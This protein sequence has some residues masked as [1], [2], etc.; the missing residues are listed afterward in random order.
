[1][2][3]NTDDLEDRV[4]EA[5]GAPHDS[6]R[7]VKGRRGALEARVTRMHPAAAVASVAVSGYV[8]ICLVF[9]A[10]G[11]L[12]THQLGSLTRWDDH[13]VRWF[14]ENRTSAMNNWT[15]YA[16]KVADTF[17]ILVVLLAVTI[18]LLLLRR[19]WEALF[20]LVALGLELLT[21]LTVNHLVDRPRPQVLRLGSLPSTSS[22]PSGHTAAMVA[23]YGGLTVLLSARFRAW[24]VGLV[25]GIM[26]V[27][28]T[29]AVGWAR[30]YRGMH[31][32][33]DVV[34]GALLG[35]AVLGVAMVAL[36]AGQRA[37]AERKRVDATLPVRPVDAELVA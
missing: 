4:K 35:L 13:V 14:T 17:G 37:A 26:A 30:V 32:P 22:F 2:D 29:A 28:A 8:L 36:R 15:D 12:V 33:S 21:F 9:A 11:M 31:H 19:R 6:N 18:V 20:L 24:I 7:G 10:L 27:L 16:T 3:P 25:S 34:A 5:V 1:M 23:L